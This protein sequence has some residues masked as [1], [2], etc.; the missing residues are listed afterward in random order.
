MTPSAAKSYHE[1]QLTA[2]IE[3]YDEMEFIKHLANA[4]INPTERQVHYMYENWRFVP[5]F[6]RFKHFYGVPSIYVIFECIN[7][8]CRKIS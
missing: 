5:F 8:R 4:Q 2:T 3:D 6:I 1:V 7:Y